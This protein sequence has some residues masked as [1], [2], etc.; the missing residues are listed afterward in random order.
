[1][2]ENNKRYSFTISILEYALSVPSLWDTV[3]GKSCFY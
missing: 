1:M 3:K 2:I